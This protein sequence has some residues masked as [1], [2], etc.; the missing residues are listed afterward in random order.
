MS[1]FSHIKWRASFG[2]PFWSSMIFC[3]QNM[4]RG[5]KKRS[6]Y[7]SL[8]QST[9]SGPLGERRPQ[10]VDLRSPSD[11]RCHPALAG[12]GMTPSWRIM[13][14]SSRTA[15]CSMALPSLKRTKCMWAC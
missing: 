7:P 5:V 2:N 11:R 9:T 3:Q 4:A 13:P 14:R 8:F 15:R 6:G 12:A 10:F 1:D